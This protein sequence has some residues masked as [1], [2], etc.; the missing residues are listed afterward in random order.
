MLFALGLNHKTASIGLRERLA[1]ADADRAPLLHALNSLAEVDE[2]ALIATCNRTECFGVGRDGAVDSVSQALTQHFRLEAKDGLDQHGFVLS[3]RDAVRHA[4][5]VASGLDSLILGEPQ[6][7]GQMKCAF[8][9][10]R[11]VGTIGWCLDRLF[12]QS[13]AVAKRVR[14]A[15]GIGENPVSVA[16]AAVRL[17]QRLYGDF[18][19][20]TALLIGAGETIELAFQHLLRQGIGRVIIANRT[21]ARAAELITKLDAAQHGE[22]IALTEL[23]ARLAEA[24][25]IISSTAAPLPILGKGA[26]ER[27]LH[28]RRRR[29][30]FMVDIA[31][32]RDIEPEV[33]H[34]EDVYLYTVDDLEDVIRENLDAR[35]AAAH[36][37]EVIIEEH[38]EAFERWRTS[39]S[40]VQRIQA[41]RGAAAAIRDRAIDEALVRL[42]RS[43]NAEEALR[44]LGHQLTNRLVHTPTVALREAVEHHDNVTAEAICRGWIEQRDAAATERVEPSFAAAANAV[45][46]S[47]DDKTAAPDQGESTR[48]RKSSSEIRS[49][50]FK[51]RLDARQRVS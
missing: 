1:V 46:V 32:P 27:A 25:I 23:P 36:Q 39:R 5:R 3:E 4:F 38:L 50:D 24:D 13:F 47:R 22:A 15:T 30:M 14:S 51:D 17:A 49:A 45:N 43:G 42:S 2:V 26:V 18:S 31:V 41:L 6:I 44:W 29:P 8:T 20:R 7:L 16:F 19:R 37:A 9:A 35:K 10:A 21:R 28:Q 11:E 33:G 40:G 34:L 12:Q 48:P